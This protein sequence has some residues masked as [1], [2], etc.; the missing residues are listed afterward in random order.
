MTIQE[1]SLQAYLEIKPKLGKKQA[2]VL[3]VLKTGMYTNSE[4]S[5]ILGWS[6][7]RITG[8]VFELRVMG[9][10]EESHRRASNTGRRAIVWK[11]K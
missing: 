7:N 4:L 11:I 2:E 9:L 3:E 5:N 8:R 6:I 1:T 10:V